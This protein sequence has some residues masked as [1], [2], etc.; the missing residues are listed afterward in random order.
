MSSRSDKQHRRQHRKDKKRRRA[1]HPEP[2]IG[3]IFVVEPPGMGKMSG[4]LWAVVEPDY[5]GSSDDD[6][7]RKLL[8][9]GSAAWNAAL[10]HGAERTALLNDLAAT[11]PEEL[12]PE[13]LAVIE[14]FIRR[15]EKLFPNIQRPILSFDLTWLLS[16]EPYL[17]VVSGLA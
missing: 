3:N 7:L 8:T 12:R 14:P 10:V 11:L 9:L 16:G 5:D 15:K 17:S 4:A 6:G 13:F 2:G 1:R